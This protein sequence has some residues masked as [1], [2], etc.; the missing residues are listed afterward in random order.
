MR[1]WMLPPIAALLVFGSARADYLFVADQTA[2]SIIRVD[3][4]TGAQAVVS[5]GGYLVNPSGIAFAPDGSLLVANRYARDIVRV[6]LATGAQS[7]VSSGGLFADP[8]NVAVAKDGSIYV[9]DTDAF[10]GPGGPG[11]II[12]VNPITGAQTAVASEGYFEKVFG[13]AL[14]ASGNIVV[15]DRGYQ[16]VGADGR[17]IEVNAATGQQT[18]LA[19]GGMLANPD[20]LAIASN[21]DILVADHD[22]FDNGVTAGGIIRV[23]PLTGAE[24][25]V[26]SGGY[27]HG[28]PSGIAIGPNGSLYI[29]SSNGAYIISVDQNGNQTLVSAGGD[30]VDPQAMVFAPSPVPEPSSLVTLSSGL[31]VLLAWRWSR[32]M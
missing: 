5:S 29:S 6:N 10:G 1:G 19:S 8:Y 13:I 32:R 30:L 11:G 12:K 20:H 22:A 23:N 25:A 24:T 26:S 31:F 21:S 14:D 15:G 4:A 28:G 9:A 27:F 7:I 16:A 2:A 3:T 17:I 18:L